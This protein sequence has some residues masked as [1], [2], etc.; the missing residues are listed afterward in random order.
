M[1]VFQTIVSFVMRLFGIRV[2]QLSTKGARTGQ[3]RTTDL[4]AIPDG[5]DAW[6]ITA[7]SAGSAKHP[8]WYFNMVKHPDDI[9]LRDSG[10]RVRVDANNLKG[11]QAESAY[12][13]LIAKWKGYASYRTKTDRE[14]PVVRLS[15]L[16]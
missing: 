10:R 9:W 3:Q 1:R 14:I 15:A 12:A 13:K 5:P 8:A 11:E 2:V 4:I 6:I 7:T 16:G